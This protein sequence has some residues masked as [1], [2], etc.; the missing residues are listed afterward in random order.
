MVEVTTKPEIRETASLSTEPPMDENSYVLLSDCWVPR[1]IDRAINNLT[2]SESSSA[3][4]SQ[5]V[6]NEAAGYLFC[7][8]ELNFAHEGGKVLMKEELNLTTYDGRKES[9]TE[10]EN[11]YKN[12]LITVKSGGESQSGKTDDDYIE[13]YV[14]GVFSDNMVYP[15]WITSCEAMG[16]GELFYFEFSSDHKQCLEYFRSQANMALF[17]GGD[18]VGEL[19]S[20]YEDKSFDCYMGVD[21]DTWLPISYGFEYVGAYTIDGNEYEHSQ[22]YYSQIWP[23]IPWHITTLRTPFSRRRNPRLPQRPCSIM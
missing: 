5:F 21:P 1:V 13:D 17:G 2:L 10:V 11:I 18:P 23:P 6:L 19:A 9:E 20:G 4:I 14:L 8:N 3:Q 7:T 12:G 22:K 15:S 16:M